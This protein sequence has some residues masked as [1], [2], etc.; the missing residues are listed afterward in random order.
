MPFVYGPYANDPGVGVQVLHVAEVEG[1]EEPKPLSPA[2][3]SAWSPN[4]TK[5][6]YLS[7]GCITGDWDIYNADPDGSSPDPV[8]ST[9]KTVKEGPYWSPTGGAIAISTFDEL[10]LLDVESGEMQTLVVSGTPESS[11]PGIHLHSPTW[12]PDGRYILFT[13]GTGHGICD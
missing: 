4:G 13:A 9:P 7:E 3:Y 5:I 11:G 10:I 12:S 1:S 6:G 8:T 2:R